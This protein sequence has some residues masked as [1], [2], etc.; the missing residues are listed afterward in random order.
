MEMQIH[1]N[2]LER[3]VQMR[4]GLQE[5]GMDGALQMTIKWSSDT[6]LLLKYCF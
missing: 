3:M 1:L 6:I 5:L 4:G 2:A